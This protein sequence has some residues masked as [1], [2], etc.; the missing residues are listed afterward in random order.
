V[1][2]CA[3]WCCCI[4]KSCSLPLPK[5][6]AFGQIGRQVS[7]FDAW[8]TGGFFCRLVSG[9]DGMPAGGLD[10]R[11]VGGNPQTGGCGRMERVILLLS[12]KW[13]VGTLGGACTLGTRCMLRVASG[14]VVSSNLLGCACK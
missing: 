4:A 14:V 7:G 9:F 11:L 13:F 1:G 5:A 6:F 12:S 3:G 8:C 2:S 10:G